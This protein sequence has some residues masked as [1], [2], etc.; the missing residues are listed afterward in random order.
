MQYLRISAGTAKY[1]FCQA[2]SR[3]SAPPFVELDKIYIFIQTYCFSSKICCKFVKVEVNIHIEVNMYFLG[4]KT[5]PTPQFTVATDCIM[6]KT[7]TAAK[8]FTMDFCQQDVSST[9]SLM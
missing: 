2:F 5:L 8:K 9:D 1:L 6:R 7:N 3:D 4:V